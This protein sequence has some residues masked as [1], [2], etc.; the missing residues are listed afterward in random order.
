[1]TPAQR[2]LLL[3]V[4]SSYAE[5]ARVSNENV[6]QL[7]GDIGVRLD[8][9]VEAS[10]ISVRA[11]QLALALEQSAQQADR[12]ERRGEGTAMKARWSRPRMRVLETSPGPD[13]DRDQYYCACGWRGRDAVDDRVC[14]VCG[15]A[16]TFAPAARTESEP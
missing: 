13:V 5:I 11:A 8:L 2:D 14:P 15:C 12:G 4:A 16:V 6:R 1:M 7:H 3:H 10:D 9:V